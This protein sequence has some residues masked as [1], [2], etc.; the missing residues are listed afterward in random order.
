MRLGTTT[1]RLDPVASKQGVRKECPYRPG[2]FVTLLPAAPFNPRWQR[3]L[4]DTIKRERA[5]RNGDAKA[6][7]E[8]EA[9]AFALDRLE[10][11]QLLVEAV[12]ADMDGIFD[13]EDKAVTYTPEVG[14][15][16]LSDE[17]NKDVTG[18]IAVEAFRWGQFYVEEVERDEKNSAAGSSGKKAG[19]GRSKKTRSS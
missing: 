17:G 4:A 14:I 12:V 1:R 16:I 8:D 5:E 3:A 10:D 15:E 11:P 13:D 2:L 19:A 18:W 6:A 7:G 9:A